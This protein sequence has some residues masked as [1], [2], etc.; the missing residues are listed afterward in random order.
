MNRHDAFHPQF[1]A[2][3]NK[4]FKVIEC[5]TFI[6]QAVISKESA[7]RGETLVRALALSS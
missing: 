1:S 2:L 6:H 5:D 7:L 3:S 4:V